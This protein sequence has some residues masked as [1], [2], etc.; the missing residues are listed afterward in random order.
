[1]SNCKSCGA[2]IIWKKTTNGKNIPLDANSEEKRAM[3]S[4]KDSEVVYIGDCYVVHWATCPN[5]DSHR[6]KGE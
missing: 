4:V 6:K 3:I 1:M 2:E 5:A